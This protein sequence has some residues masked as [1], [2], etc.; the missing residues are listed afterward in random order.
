MKDL[1]RQQYVVILCF[2]YIVQ[3]TLSRR[4]MMSRSLSKQIKTKVE[5][6][7]HYTPPKY[8]ILRR[9]AEPLFTAAN[10]VLH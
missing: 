5:R 10:V 9:T 2:V 7:I 1:S 4:L 8:Q 6:S 3:L